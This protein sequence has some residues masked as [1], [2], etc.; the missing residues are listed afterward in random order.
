MI[1]KRK[2]EKFCQLLVLHWSSS[3][4]GGS[5]SNE[6]GKDPSFFNVTEN[7]VRVSLSTRGLIRVSLI[8]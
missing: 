1:N 6:R 2:D 8:T 3:L 4:D 5:I 7:V